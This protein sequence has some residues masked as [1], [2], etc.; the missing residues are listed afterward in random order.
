M[1]G[2]STC[3]CSV[4]NQLCKGTEVNGSNLNRQVKEKWRKAEG[5]PDEGQADQAHFYYF[6][7]SKKYVL[8]QKAT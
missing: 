8:N 4:S 2:K 1:N 7:N 6:K 5:M 3:R